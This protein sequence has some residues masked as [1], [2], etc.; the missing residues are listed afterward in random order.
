MLQRTRHPELKH[1]KP[2]VWKK[3][4]CKIEDLLTHRVT[5]EKCSITE[6]MEAWCCDEEEVKSLLFMYVPKDLYAE[7]TGLHLTDQVNFELSAALE[8]EFLLIMVEFQNGVWKNAGFL[9]SSKH[10]FRSSILSVSVDSNAP[11]VSFKE[12]DLCEKSV[13]RVEF[14]ENYLFCAREDDAS[15]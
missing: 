3:D 8:D 1:S 7:A 13:K 11:S 9:P 15:L 12:F 14:T 10:C 2:S 5:E 6:W 4:P